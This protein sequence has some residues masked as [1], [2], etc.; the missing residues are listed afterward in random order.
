MVHGATP[1]GVP[2]TTG[3]ET[4]ASNDRQMRCSATWWGFAA[5]GLAAH[6]LRS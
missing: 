5:H 1:G 3:P 2:Q 4:A 6:G